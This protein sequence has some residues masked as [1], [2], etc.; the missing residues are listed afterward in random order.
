M[1]KIISA[2]TP[3]EN[4]FD[5]DLYVYKQT[6]FSRMLNVFITFTKHDQK[7]PKNTFFHWFPFFSCLVKGKLLSARHM[8]IISTLVSF[9]FVSS[10]LCNG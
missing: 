5:T 10:C 2:R 9:L 3:D 6:H 8:R 4:H 7:F 1:G